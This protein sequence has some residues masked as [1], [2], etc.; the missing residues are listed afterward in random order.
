MTKGMPFLATC[1]SR[2][3]HNEYQAELV[4]PSRAELQYRLKH[5]L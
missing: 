3:Q 2:L 1:R 5:P 4:R